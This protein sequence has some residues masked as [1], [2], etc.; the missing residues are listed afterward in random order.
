MTY[1]L[2]RQPVALYNHMGGVTARADTLVCLLQ[3]QARFYTQLSWNT[4]FNLIS[5]LRANT[6]SVR[7]KDNSVDFVQ[8][9]NLFLVWEPYETKYTVGKYQ[10]KWLH[11][12]G[13][14]FIETK[15]PVG[16]E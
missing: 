7:Y 4:Y 6:C 12:H 5:P 15:Y 11:I 8:K 3:W 14:H 1:A 9:S 2:V 13:S 16:K 10:N